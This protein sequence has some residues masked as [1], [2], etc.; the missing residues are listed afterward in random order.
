MKVRVK[1]NSQVISSK[2]FIKNSCR[3]F[4]FN[5]ALLLFD[6]IENM[7]SFEDRTDIWA[8]L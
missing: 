8:A 4:S 2:I 1:N 5:D 6:S 3:I 7:K